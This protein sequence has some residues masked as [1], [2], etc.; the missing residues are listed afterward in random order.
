MPSSATEAAIDAINSVVENGELKDIDCTELAQLVMSGGD[1]TAVGVLVRAQAAQILTSDDLRNGGF[2]L[3]LVNMISKMK[4]ATAL[5][6]GTG[7]VSEIKEDPHLGKVHFMVRAAIYQAIHKGRAAGGTTSDTVRQRA[8]VE[9][10]M[11]AAKKDVNILAYILTMDAGGR[12]EECKAKLGDVEIVKVAKDKDLY[13]KDVGIYP[14]ITR[15][16]TRIW[17]NSPWGSSR[18]G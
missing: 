4:Q 1:F 11:N 10:A 6:A 13:D 14:A 2:A 18:V 5:I 9:R 17:L 16:S 7:Q 15:A 8:D 3:K 12:W